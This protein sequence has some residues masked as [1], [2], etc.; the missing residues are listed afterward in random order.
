MEKEEAIKILR[1][2]KEDFILPTGRVDNKRLLDTFY[3][4]LKQ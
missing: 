2:K 4:L 1:G 3:S